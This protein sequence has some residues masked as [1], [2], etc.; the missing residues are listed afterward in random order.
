MPHFIKTGYW[1]K[2]VKNYKGWLDLEQLIASVGPPGN[3]ATLQSVLDANAV[4]Y[5]QRIELVGDNTYISTQSY[6]DDVAGPIASSIE[7]YMRFQNNHI[8][9]TNISTQYNRIVFTQT[10]A[11]S[12]TLV[13]LSSAGNC[14]YYF[15][16]I[17]NTNG[18]LDIQYLSGPVFYQNYF[19]FRFQGAPNS[20]SRIEGFNNIF[21]DQDLG[22]GGFGSTF[23]F[24]GI[25]S[26][27]YISI[28]NA[29]SGIIYDSTNTWG[30]YDVGNKIYFGG[31]LT[32][33]QPI[34]YYNSTTNS[35]GSASGE[36]LTVYIN[37][38]QRKIALLNP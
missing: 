36:Y 28:L 11:N 20:T 9:S 24:D 12:N 15:D 7:K 29:G 19:Q 5:N 27:I 33:G 2:A 35:A 16:V 13:E 14:Q 30:I 34:N 26:G 21:I 23:E 22:S 17:P 37:G 25:R 8:E 38:V 6:S 32:V 1:E 10:L 3:I 4:A 31:T 18:N